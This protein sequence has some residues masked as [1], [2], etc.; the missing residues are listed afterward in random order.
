MNFEQFK[1]DL[2]AGVVVLDAGL[3]TSLEALGHDLSGHLWSARLLQDQPAAIS[4]VHA[5]HI[6]AGARIV[7]TASYQ[8]SRSGFVSAG[9]AASDAD[10][11]IARSVQIARSV[12]QR[13]ESATGEPVLVA[14]SLG[15]YG[16]TLADG[17]EY[18]GDYSISLDNLTTF[19]RERIAVM[20]AAAPD[21]LA[22]ETLPSAMEVRVINHLLSTEFTDIPAWMSC[23]ANGQDSIADGTSAVEVLESITADCVVA[24]GFN[25]IAPDLATPLLASIAHHRSDLPRIIYTNSGKTWDAV[26]RVWLDEG[27]EVIPQPVLSEWVSLGARIIGGCCGLGEPHIRNVAMMKVSAS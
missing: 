1:S 27:T 6:Q 8:A 5:S 24:F 10:A 12:A 4:Q 13:H 16:A 23:S 11:A 18:R 21:L 9:L 15:A 3:A 19:H 2:A 14:G 7:T 17:S 25:C 26:Q 20:T 22:F